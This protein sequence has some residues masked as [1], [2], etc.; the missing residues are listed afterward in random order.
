MRA[1]R[2]ETWSGQKFDSMLYKKYKE[3]GG[4]TPHVD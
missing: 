2:S 4:K 3:Y 1:V